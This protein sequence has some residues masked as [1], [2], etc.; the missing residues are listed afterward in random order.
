MSTKHWFLPENPDLFGMLQEQAAITMEGMQALVRW[1]GGDVTGADTVRACEHRA[2]D[3]KRELWRKLRDAFSPPIDAEDLYSLS[4]DLDEVL[5]AAK[6]LIR[7]AEI[8][9]TAPDVPTE[10]MAGFLAESVA[11]LA[12][13]FSRLTNKDGD[14]T[15]DADLAI[16]SQRHVEKTYR[17]AMS[18][19]M[20]R[21]DLRQV[22]VYRELYHRM[23]H[24]GDLTHVVAER[25]WYAVVKEG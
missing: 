24:I 5:N 4:A 17:A 8:V 20:D 25:V 13:A 16:K 18:A 23:L 12:D 6:D 14:P 1:A 21:D 7:E 19:L 22:I 3:K 15:V 10:E 9:R 2:D 11:H